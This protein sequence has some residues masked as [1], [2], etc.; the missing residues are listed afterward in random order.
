MKIRLLPILAIIIL[1]ISCSETTSSGDELS[2]LGFYSDSG[3]IISTLKKENDSPEKNYMLGK[4]FL[5][6]KQYKQSILHFANSCFKSERNFKLRLFPHPVY[7][8]V[9]GFH[10]KSRYYNDSVYNIALLF[11]KYREYDYVIKFIDLMIENSTAL[12]RDAVVLKSKALER[13]KKNEEAIT[14]LE[15]LLKRYNDSYSKAALHIR[16]ASIHEKQSEYRKASANYYKIL[17]LSADNWQKSIAADH[18]QYMVKDN[19]IKIAKEDAIK[20]AAALFDSGKIDESKKILQNITEKNFGKDIDSLRIKL[21]T[22]KSLRE[23]ESF[24]KSLK[25]KKYYDHIALSFAN[26]LWSNGQKSRSLHI[27]NSLIQSLDDDI[28]ER[29][30]TRLSY[31]YEDRN[32]PMLIKYMSLYIERFKNSPQAAKFLW[33]MSRYYIRNNSVDAALQH[34]NILVSRHPNSPY[35]A[36]GLYWKLRL[37]KKIKKIDTATEHNLLADM[38]YYNPSSSYTLR[39]LHSRALSTPSEIIIKKFKNYKNKKEYKSML[40]YSSLLFLKEGYSEKIKEMQ[41]DFPDDILSLFRKFSNIIENNSYKTDSKSRLQ[42]LEKYFAV[43]D[44][45]SV[46]RELNIIENNDEDIKYDI[47]LTLSSLGYKYSNYHYSSFYSFRLL[48]LSNSREYLPFMKKA[49]ARRLYPLAFPE[50]LNQEAKAYKLNRSTILSMIK[51]ESYFIP[52]A[53]SPVGARGLLQ[54]MPPTARGIAK[55]LKIRK[56]NLLDPCTSVKFGANYINW[57]KKYYKG[58]IEYMVAA[59]NA[60]AGNVNKWIK[61][62]RDKDMDYFAEFTP[63]NETRYYIYSTQKFKIQYESIDKMK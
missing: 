32:N 56:F 63:F 39:E 18:I 61:R 47:A 49:E 57:L 5:E 29:V 45:E 25:D 55:T 17:E 9:D 38:N 12:C 62:Y 34:I 59:Y 48:S 33:L 46:R 54:L 19:K 24:L 11:Y 26:N 28:A 3:K 31:Y 22:K 42:K 23:G 35:S 40:L 10:F 44:D 16:I 13:K 21:L 43:G 37:L 8:F 2:K 53:I 50:C 1:F 6:K 60:G 15:K 7:S 58:K 27:Y 20:L 36:N 4:A 41:S 52:S 30:L 51:A 14:I